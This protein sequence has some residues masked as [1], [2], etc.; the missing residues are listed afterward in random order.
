MHEVAESSTSTL[1]EY[2]DIIIASTNSRDTDDEHVPHFVLPAAS[3]SE[4]SDW[5]ELRVNG[6][7]IEPAIVESQYS[8]LCILLIAKL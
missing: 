2:N 4:V 7:A 3:L 5:G 8:I 6:L 1:P